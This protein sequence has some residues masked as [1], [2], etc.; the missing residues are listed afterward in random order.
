MNGPRGDD[1]IAAQAV[2]RDDPFGGGQLRM[3][4]ER[5]QLVQRRSGCRAARVRR[6]HAGAQ[7]ASGDV[8]TSGL[9]RCGSLIKAARW[10]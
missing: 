1:R 5:Q 4:R 8:D 7:A 6:P 3:R 9:A 10:V 2:Q